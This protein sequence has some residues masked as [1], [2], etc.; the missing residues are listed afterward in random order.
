MIATFIEALAGTIG[1]WI[2]LFV[3]RWF[4]RPASRAAPPDETPAPLQARFKSWELYGS[5]VA[6]ALMAP[7]GYAW[8]RYF[9]WLRERRMAEFAEAAFLYRPDAVVMGIV[10]GFVGV[11]SAI[12]VADHVMRT[13]LGKHAA[14]AYRA[15]ED[16]KYRVNTDAA[17]TFIYMAISVPALFLLAAVV[18]HYAA[19][20]DNEIVVDRFWGAAERRYEY[21]DVERIVTAGQFVAPVRAKRDRWLFV[22]HFK[23]GR[24][25]NSTGAPSPKKLPELMEFVSERSG[26]PIE[27]LPVLSRDLL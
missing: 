18:D 3:L 25:W 2:A 19:F 21:A 27:K 8:F 20:S 14:R 12:F 5:I 7:A 23:D 11:V 24:T 4:L 10:A 9:V 17:S 6:V 22:I 13:L 1:L 16:R 26:V 15:Y